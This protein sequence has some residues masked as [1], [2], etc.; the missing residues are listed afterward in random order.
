MKRIYKYNFSIQDQ[1]K[2]STYKGAEIVHV[3]IDPN[4]QAAIWMMIDPAEVSEDRHFRIY[5]TGH[6]IVS[7]NLERVSSFVDG[8]FVWHLFEYKN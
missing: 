6:D 3:G 8:R 5:G 7:E 1:F 2:I 4:N